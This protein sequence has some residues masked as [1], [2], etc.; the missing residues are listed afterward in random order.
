MIT[1]EEVMTALQARLTLPSLKTISRRNRAPETLSPSLTPALMLIG[2]REQF[3]RP[4]LSAPP[5]ITLHILAILY[6]DVGN[7]ENAIPDGI[8]NNLLDEITAALE[9]D[10]RNLGRLTLHGLVQSV[11]I[12]GEIT[13]AP[14]DV[15][16][17]GLAVIPITIRFMQTL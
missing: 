2:H 15:T 5:K 10:D 4:S 8:L 16:G 13:K 3:E 1:R 12:D 7:D 6:I 14:G 9:P 11:T 17:K